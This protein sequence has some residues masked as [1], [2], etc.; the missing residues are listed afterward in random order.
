[1]STELEAP[2]FPV[3]IKGIPDSFETLDPKL[4]YEYKALYDFICQNKEKLQIK[5]FQYALREPGSPENDVKAVMHVHFF[6]KQIVYDLVRPR[7]LS[8]YHF[9]T[10]IYT[11]LYVLLEKSKLVLTK[12]W[13][14]IILDRI[15]KNDY[16]ILSDYYEDFFTK[17]L[18]LVNNKFC[19]ASI[20]MLAF[21][22]TLVLLDQWR[23]K[24]FVLPRHKVEWNGVKVMFLT[25]KLSLVWFGNSF[26][27]TCF[28]KLNRN[29]RTCFLYPVLVFALKFGFDLLVCL[30]HRTVYQSLETTSEADIRLDT[31]NYP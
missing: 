7:D 25:A 29:F 10:L 6:L 24:Y 3:F 21:F 18:F 22:F 9:L 23:F 1:M 16:A 8:F 27:K 2:N 15:I 14:F 13:F 19:A 5:F 4:Y 30:R 28:P 31:T 17:F 11:K 20:T 26:L 12:Q